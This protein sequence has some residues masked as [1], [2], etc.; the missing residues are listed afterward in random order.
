MS[1]D[2]WVVAFGLASVLLGMGIANRVTAV[3][4]FSMVAG[5]DVWLLYRFFRNRHQRI[6]NLSPAPLSDVIPSR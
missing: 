6:G 3:G 5:F 1:F 4:L 2:A